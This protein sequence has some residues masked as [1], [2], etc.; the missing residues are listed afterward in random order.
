MCHL[1]IFEYAC[2][3]KHSLLLPC[4]EVQNSA[5]GPDF[6]CLTPIKNT[7]PKYAD[8]LCPKCR[9]AELKAGSEREEPETSFE[10]DPESGGLVLMEKESEMPEDPNPGNPT[11]ER[12]QGDFVGQSW[13]QISGIC[14]LG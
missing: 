5:S 12:G 4:K 14:W 2:T 6:P 11:Q 13:G 10:P 9:R 1:Q 7:I 8:R 3:H